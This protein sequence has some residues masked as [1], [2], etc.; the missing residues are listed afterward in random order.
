MLEIDRAAQRIS[1]E[2]G[3]PINIRCAAINQKRA[4]ARVVHSNL[5]DLQGCRKYVVR[6]LTSLLCR[7]SFAPVNR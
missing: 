3:G 4:K 6:H 5:F 2:L 7:V 1:P